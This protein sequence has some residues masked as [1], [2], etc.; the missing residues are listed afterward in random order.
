M[1]LLERGPYSISCMM[2]LQSGSIILVLPF[3]KMLHWLFQKRILFCLA[4]KAFL[5]MTGKLL[6]VN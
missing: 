2:P 6:K 1:G 5:E 4:S 3:S